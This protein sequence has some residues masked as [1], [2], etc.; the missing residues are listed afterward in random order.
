MV[1]RPSWTR[2]R[3]LRAA[4]LAPLQSG[5]S[6]IAKPRNEIN[7]TLVE[8]P[9]VLNRPPRITSA[10]ILSIIS[11]R[12]S[13][14]EQL[15]ALTMIADPE[16]PVRWRCH[17]SLRKTV[18]KRSLLDEGPAWAASK[19]VPHVA[20]MNRFSRAAMRGRVSGMRSQ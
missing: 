3:H 8:R 2:E 12:F 5:L 7:I 6:Q 14:L 20:G 1:Y 13:R 19:Q 18:P 9:A 17:E 10:F 16:K 4:I 15:S 11:L